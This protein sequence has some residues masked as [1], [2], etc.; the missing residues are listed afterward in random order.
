MERASHF[1]AVSGVQEATLVQ[2][3]LQQP[4]SQQL[5]AALTARRFRRE[6]GSNE[7]RRR[8][9]RHAPELGA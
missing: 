7:L 9:A 2:E 4:E 8:R 6:I 5:A 1:H 3:T